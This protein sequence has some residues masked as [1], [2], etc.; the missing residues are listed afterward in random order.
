[1]T[2]NAMA[3][4]R[5]MALAAGM[6]DHISKPLNVTTMFATMSKWIRP[7]QPAVAAPPAAQ[8][9][10]ADKMAAALPAQLPGIDQ[11]AGLATSMGRQELYL[12]MLMR[13]RDGHARLREDFEAA[14]QS[15]DPTAAARVAHTLRG[16]AGN[17]GA[18][19]VAATATALELAC[20]AGAAEAELATLLTAVENELAPV[21]SGL[22]ALVNYTAA[23][24]HT[25][26]GAIGAV[27]ALPPDA[28]A[29]LAHLRKLL[30]DS[31]TAALDVLE[32]LESQATGHPLARQ[33]RKVS[34]AIERFDFDA[35]L[36]AL[37][38]VAQPA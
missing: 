26:A 20:K 12:R 32:T 27:S 21:L 14:R 28:A 13:F 11:R 16:T 35:A 19:G 7:A 22:A 4:D 8:P 34:Q 31:D 36:E 24:E 33:L 15:D 1:M 5:E 25:P 9:D 18:K 3:G 10:A 17:V 6:N 2:A 30:A 23:A 29:T 37:D 38:A